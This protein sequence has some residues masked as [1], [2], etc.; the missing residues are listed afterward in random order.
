MHPLPLRGAA[1][2]A[3]A[4]AA[5]ALAVPAGT[6]ASGATA[7]VAAAPAGAALDTPVWAQRVCSAVLDWSVAA[8]RHAEG[9]DGKVSAADLRRSRAVLSRFLDQV[10][11]ETDRMITRVD[12]AGTPALEQGP[13]IRQQLRA[14]LKRARGLLADARRT[15]AGLSVTDKEAF[16]QG[17]SD[18]GDRIEQQFGALA[19]ALE[20]IDVRYPSKELDAAVATAPACKKL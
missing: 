2:A 10:V 18:L 15:A 14:S 16:A 11:R 9:L 20:Q 12:A 17:A 19:G 13:A 1:V 7:A 8:G 6:Q 3:V 5:L 4:A